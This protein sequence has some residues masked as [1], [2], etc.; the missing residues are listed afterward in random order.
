MKRRP[1]RV[2]GGIGC[3]VA[4]VAT[5]R[6]APAA[7]PVLAAAGDIA[8]A[9]ESAD[10]NGGLGTATACRMMATAN[11]LVTRAPDVVMPLGDTQYEDGAPAR[12]ALSYHPSWGQ[13][14]ARTRPVVGNHE[15]GTPGAAGY[16]SYF[17]PAAGDPSKGTYGFDLGAWRV[18]VLNSNCAAAG[19][20][21]AG[22]PQETWLR[23]ELAA[24]P[25]VCTLAAMH[26]PRFSSGMHGNDT[27]TSAFWETLFSAGADVVLTGHDHDYERFGRQR[28]D[29]TPDALRGI[30][31]FVVGTGGKDTRPFG[32]VAANSRVRLTGTF[33]VLELTLRPASYDWAFVAT[34]GSVLDAGTGPCHRAP[35]PK[36]FHTLPPCRLVD[37][38]H[39][40]AP[41]GGPALAAGETRAFALRGACGIPASAESLVLNVTAVTPTAGGRLLVGPSGPATNASQ[42]VAFRTGRTRAGHTI[43]WL[44][45]DGALAVTADLPSGSTHVVLDV[46]GYFE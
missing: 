37:T 21:E 39:P 25:G 29:G 14:L 17:G 10:F 41:L 38:R 26:H 2:L 24:H 22:S 4:F 23:Q 27:S 31:E 15:Y 28:P 5:A 20:C 9:P 1:A 30:R 42:V 35:L 33:G 40:A 18:L 8:C 46:A 19:G 7:D 6:T 32:A 34:D 13:L 11:L 36:R 3:L 16:F 44:G 12:F 43:A 45:N